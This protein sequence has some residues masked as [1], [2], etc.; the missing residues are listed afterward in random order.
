MPGLALL[1][2]AEAFLSLRGVKTLAVRM[3]RH[4]ENA[5]PTGRP[6]RAFGTIPSWC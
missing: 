1:L 2:V 4:C 3:Q 5:Q 6:S